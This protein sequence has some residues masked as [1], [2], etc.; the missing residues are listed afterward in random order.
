MELFELDLI[1]YYEFDLIVLCYI[2]EVISEKEAVNEGVI[3]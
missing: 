3:Y 2:N 1:D